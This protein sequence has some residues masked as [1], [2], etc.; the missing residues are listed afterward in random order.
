METITTIFKK[1]PSTARAAGGYAMR[2]KVQA[3]IAL[4]VVAGG[5][6]YGYTVWK[7][8]HTPA[9]YVL[10]MATIAP[11]ETTVTGS[12]QVASSHELDLSPKASGAITQINVKAGDHVAAG[13]LVASIESTDAQKNVRDAS[14]SLQSAKISYAQSTASANTSIQTA[15]DTAYDAVSNAET[16]QPTVLQHL[17]TIFTTGTGLSAYVRVIENVEPSAQQ[18]ADRARAS[19]LAAVTAHDTAVLAYRQANRTDS[20]Q[21]ILTLTTTEYASLVATTQ[22]VNDTLTFFSLV[23]QALKA[24]DLLVAPSDFSSTFTEVSSDSSTITSATTKVSS[25]QTTLQNDI[26]SL[27]SGVPLDIQSAQL[28]LTKAQN[29]YQDALDTLADYSVRAPFAGTIAKVNLQKFDQAGGSTAVATLITDQEF[30]ELSLNETDA[31]KVKVGQKATLTF[32]AIDGLS[33]DGTVAEVDQVGTVSSGVVSYAVKIDLGAG[34][35]RIRPGM[36]VNATIVTASKD[37]AL[38]VPSAAIKSQGD[39]YY[40]EVA[41][42][43]TAAA[44]Q[45]DTASSTR[46]MRPATSTGAMASSTRTF[47]A[48]TNTVS[49]DEVTITRVPVTLGLQSDTMTEVLTGLTAGERVVT[50]TIAVSGKTTSTAKS[51]T[52]LL[53]GSRQNSSS[54]SA[55]GASAG[56]AT[57]RTVG[58]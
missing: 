29:A 5:A 42:P 10:A 53:G 3:G 45:T 20:P 41:M 33:I 7:A 48:R 56:N 19:Y 18:V 26:R 15:R 1:I 13:Q 58:P 6:Y 32:D 35:D 54:G 27:G 40:I 28:T 37:A 30:A 39:N 31:A 11:I 47:G 12:G 36:T 21:D 25:A 43:K 24:H 57:F 17:D 23:D 34:D 8:D 14:A 52:S 44:P 46:R 55:R 49:A 2:H 22:A 4:I 50:S 38:V 9:Q 16:S 51:A